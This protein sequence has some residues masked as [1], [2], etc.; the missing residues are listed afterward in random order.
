MA[1][2]KNYLTQFYI[3]TYLFCFVALANL[4][5]FCRYGDNVVYITIAFWCLYICFYNLFIFFYFYSKQALVMTTPGI[6]QL[7]Q[8][9]KKNLARSFFSFYHFKHN[10]TF[11]GNADVLLFMTC[12][13]E[14][15]LLPFTQKLFYLRLLT[16]LIH[17][18]MTNNLEFI[19]YTFKSLRKAQAPWSAPTSVGG[20]TGEVAL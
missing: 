17:S 16:F 1:R 14:C 10:F 8:N 4:I 18:I 13:K 3:F 12:H 6:Q 9:H 19:L 7:C 20:P 5:A 15:F 2:N 11:S